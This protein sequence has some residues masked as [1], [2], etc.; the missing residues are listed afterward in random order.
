M[1]SPADAAPRAEGADTVH[2]EGASTVQAESAC[3]AHTEAASAAHA[4]A[5][6]SAP[7]WTHTL[8]E[9]WTALPGLLN[10]R[11]ELLSLELQRAA[12]ALAQTVLLIVVSGILG[13]TSWL[14]LW[15]VIVGALVDAGWHSALALSLAMGINLG[16]A[17]WTALRARRLLPLLRL[18]ATRRHLMIKP[19]SAPRPGWSGRA[20]TAESPDVARP[21]TP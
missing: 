8:G 3:G 13:V 17:A 4:E 21:A 10:D 12:A 7:S 5:A 20:P 11:I 19:A 6:S 14:L 2:A 1:T 15:A 9:I 16:A 18:P